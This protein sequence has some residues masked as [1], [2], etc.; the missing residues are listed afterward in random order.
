M[1]LSRMLTRTVWV[2]A[3]CG[4][5]A[6]PALRADEQERLKVGLQP[7]GRIVVP[8]NQILRPAGQQV[9]F[10]GRPVDLAFADEGKTLV[11]KNMR[12]LVFIDTATG[13]IKQTLTASTGF[14]VVGLLVEG[15]RVYV[16]DVLNH[17]RVA[18]RQPDGSYRWGQPIAL[19]V[20]KV[21][22]GAHPAG[23]ARLS[24]EELA[25]A[26]TVGNSI[27]VIDTAEGKVKQVVP[28]GVAPYMV[29]P[30]PPGRVYVSNWGGD[31]PKEGDLTAPSS[32]TPVRVDSRGI[33]N[34]GSVSVLERIDGQWKQVRTIRVGLHPSG[35]TVSPGRRFVYVA[36]ANSDTVSVIDTQNDEVV[37]TI[38][39]RPE[40]RLPFGSGANALA[41]S[42]DGQTL[43]VANGT[44]NCLAVVRL[45][46]KACEATDPGRPAASALLGLIPTGW[47]P[48]AVL[49]SADGRRLFVANIKGHGSLSRRRITESEPRPEEKG[50]N[51]HDHLGSVS[52]IEVPDAQQL[53][54]YTEEVN[55]NNR[56]AYSLAGLEKPRPGV[57]PVPVPRRHG[58]PSVF[59][60]VIYIIKENRTYDQVFGDIKEGNGDPNLVMFG[61]EV[62]P[63]HHALARQF[64][65]FDNFYC[66]GVLSAD[67]HQW[68][69][70]AYVT[71]YLERAFGGFTRSYPYEG[72][73]PLA[74]A[75]SGFLWDNALA[76]KKTFRNYGEFVR[77][78][79]PKGTT[80]SDVYA[81]YRNGTRKVKIEVRPNVKSL[82]PYTHPGY[83]GFPLIT[84]DVYR[85]RLFIE[86]LKEYEKK[87]EF[88]NLVYVFLPCDHTNGTRPGFP[89]PRAMVAD[90]DLA[91]GQ[92]VE[93][94]S[95][96]K[97]WPKTCIFVVEDDPQNGFDHVDAHRTVA[98]VISPYT[99]R[100]YVDSTNYNQT[101]MVKTI[102]LILGLPPMNQLDLS[103]TAMRDCFQEQPDLTPYTALPN[104]IALDEMNPP[105]EELKGAALH[106]AKKSLELSFAKEDEADED[107][108]NRILWHATR[109]YDT[110][111]PEQFAGRRV[112]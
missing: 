1:T 111:Y 16:G 12:S 34:H 6:W 74:Y 33:A 58:E 70:E 62:T 101:G 39:C 32:G 2:I 77:S 31:P 71:D 10:P 64:T 100:R 5:A 23:M 4:L 14:S 85:A 88:P 54:K 103:A 50:R 65:L 9:L 18:E 83:P 15:D 56:L 106:W 110:P 20:P 66:S 94:V 29:C 28:V 42:P 46:A 90:N 68:L 40:A 7:D 30:V 75:S 38:A 107:T 93:A 13:E 47:Y 73:D 95:K 61:E 37:E 11:V 97:F 53:A 60:H 79:Y 51:S 87:G 26:S 72:S 86:E 96:S 102:E 45:G 84:P 3:C 59:E 76:H 108:L 82:E 27:Q 81:D 89:T 91:L 52:I 112:E 98:L 17:V 25:V 109:G 24:R 63:N 57:K 80:W 8:T 48:G 35:M 19:V 55:A 22:K 67:G 69:N 49:L 78:S 104:K 41:L 105:L 99:K 36:N 92:I 21:G 43:Y 44:N